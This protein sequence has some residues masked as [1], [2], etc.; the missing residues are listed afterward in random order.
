[1]LRCGAFRDEA[2]INLINRRFVATY[3]DV[4]APG[5]NSGDAWAYDE[6]AMTAIGRPKPPRW[7]IPGGTQ[8][9]D[10]R[11][12]AGTYPTGIFV[13]P[14][15]RILGQGL[16]GILGPEVLHRELKRVLLTYPDHATATPAEIEAFSVAAIDRRDARAQLSAARICWE[17]GDW[18]ASLAYLADGL[19]ASAADELRA[20]LYYLRARVLL[21]R[22][23]PT[24]ARE[25]LLNAESLAEEPELVD[26][27]RAAAARSWMQEGQFDRAQE[28]LEGLIASNSSW[29]GFGRYFAG[30]CRYRR[31]DETGAK[32]V[33]RAHKNELPMDRLARRSAASLGL[34][35]S[36]AF[37]N[38]QLFER[39]G[40]W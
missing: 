17:T 28:L 26:A 37:M 38:Q 24:L 20:E 23:Q 12:R 33:W 14:D 2:C 8:Y 7:A 5:R 4:A 18:D 11:V 13:A 15:G 30:L 35:E 31:G 10:G 36:E 16:W 22:H 6:D 29:Q 1:M 27:I 3:F 21:C 25:Q 40:W 19:A 9:R 32:A 34:P 39:D